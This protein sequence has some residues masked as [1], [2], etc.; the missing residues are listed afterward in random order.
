MA[1]SISHAQLASRL[2][3]SI[4]DFKTF[5]SQRFLDHEARE[6]LQARAS[7][8]LIDRRFVDQDR[9]LDERFGTQTKAL[10]AAFAAQQTAMATALSAATQTEERMSGRI[11]DVEER[12][13]Q[14][15]GRALG[16]SDM[17]GW[18][19]AAFTIVGTVLYHFH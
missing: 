5:V 6:D 8:A 13:M 1:D 17:V 14:G 11:K 10:D 19:I 4:V 3:Q 9:L 12:Q 2:D 15:G 16:R 18:F 7:A